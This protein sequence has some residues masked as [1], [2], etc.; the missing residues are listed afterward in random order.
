M[1]NI[2]DNTASCEVMHRV[3]VV[4]SNDV[5]FKTLATYKECVSPEYMALLRVSVKH[6][7]E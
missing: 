7:N 1:H 4:A 6:G 5:S 3:Q 2:N